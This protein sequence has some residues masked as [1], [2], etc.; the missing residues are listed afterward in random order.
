MSRPSLPSTARIGDLMGLRADVDVLPARKDGAH[1]T[2]VTS[3]PVRCGRSAVPN[4]AML[5][6]ETS[7]R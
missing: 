5:A 1:S 4:L 7:T 6:P 3:E 2:I